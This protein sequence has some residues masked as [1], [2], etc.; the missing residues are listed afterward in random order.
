[1]RME[2]QK[3]NE[4]IDK[5]LLQ[6]QK[7]YN[8]RLNDFL[9]ARRIFIDLTG[10]IPTYKELVNFVNQKNKNKRTFLI[11]KLLESEGYVSHTYNY[12]ADLLRIQTKI[13]GQKTYSALFS[14]WLKDS[15]HRDKPYNH[16]V[17]M[18]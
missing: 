9:Y 8:P 15:I 11:N 14:G 4:I 6:Q 5:K 16:M 7:S 18:K 3:I 13:P 2:V 10:T 1:M 12:F 17:Y